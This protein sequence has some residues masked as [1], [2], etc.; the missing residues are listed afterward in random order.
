MGGGVTI[1]NGSTM[2]IN[3]GEIT[4]NIATNRGGAICFQDANT[5]V[6]GSHL[7]IYD[8]DIHANYSQSSSGGAININNSIASSQNI[9]DMYG[10]KIY[11]GDAVLG[12]N[13][14]VY[15][16]TTGSSATVNFYGGEV[17]AAKTGT[18]SEAEFQLEEAV[19]FQNGDWE[20]GAVSEYIADENLTMIPL[21][22][23]AEGE[24][25]QGLCT[26]TE[27]FLCVNAKASEA[28]I[29]ATLDFLYWLVNAH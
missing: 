8:A 12:D 16:L 9:V 20:Y 28:D 14:Y 17:G 24:E 29:Q 23:G 3:S 15:A 1:V 26:G 27:N 25:N 7:I 22:I 21:Y 5:S 2:V 4:G 19:F 13:V 10:G 6:P 11:N 18:D